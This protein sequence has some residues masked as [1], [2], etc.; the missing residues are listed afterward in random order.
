MGRY[1]GR[2]ARVIPGRGAG[3]VL[4]LS[5]S[6]ASTP[7]SAGRWDRARGEALVRFTHAIS[8]KLRRHD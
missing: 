7:G 3:P 8:F 6:S 2:I 5:W 1:L 4:R